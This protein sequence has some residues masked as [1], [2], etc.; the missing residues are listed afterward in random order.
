MSDNSD[1]KGFELTEAEVARLKTLHRQLPR[2]R[3]ADIIKA[4]LLLGTGWTERDVAEALLLDEKTVS[5][6]VDRYRQNSQG[7]FWFMDYQGSVSKLTD[8]QLSRLDQ[9]LQSTLYLTV[10]AIIGYV[11]RTFGILYSEQGITNLLHRMGFTYKKPKAFPGK[12]DAQAQRAFVKTYTILK[13]R[14]KSEINSILWMAYI[15]STIVCQ[16][17]AGS[18]KD[19]CTSCPAIRV[20]SG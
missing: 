9:H 8:S 18:K 4:V 5:R 10:G 3:D 6:Y 17:M 7:E 16:P 12:A 14:R 20:G 13:R 2:R 15:R 1:M 19:R 11:E